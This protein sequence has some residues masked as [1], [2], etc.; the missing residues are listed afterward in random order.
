[1]YIQRVF[2]ERVNNINIYKYGKNY[3]NEMP[4]ES[5]VVVSK[6][7]DAARIKAKRNTKYRSIYPESEITLRLTLS[8][9]DCKRALSYLPKLPST[10]MIRNKLQAALDRFDEKKLRKELKANGIIK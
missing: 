2:I 10:E 9:R 6:T 1:M 3:L 5:P 4:D 7:L 8:M